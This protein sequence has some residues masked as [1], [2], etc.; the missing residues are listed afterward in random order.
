M[1]PKN[2]PFEKEIPLPNH[3]VQLQNVK[4]RGSIAGFFGGRG[5]GGVEVLKSTILQSLGGTPGQ[6]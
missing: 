1:E 6:V 3:H 4:F 2:H 5:G